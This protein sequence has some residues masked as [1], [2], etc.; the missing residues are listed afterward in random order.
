MHHFSL[1]FTALLASAA[2]VFSSC[3][4]GAESADLSG[5]WNLKTIDGVEVV[6]PEDQ[7]SIE[8]SAKQ[9]HL[10]TGINIVNGNYSVKKDVLKMEEGPMTRMA[11]SEEGMNL[12]TKILDF[13]F[14]PLEVDVQENVLTLT[15]SN[16][17]TMQFFKN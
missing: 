11:G 8:F 1:I 12:E 17:D 14:N 6:I 16:G 7:P 9:Y 13:L 5:V 10:Q 3:K 2:L 15:S 4:G